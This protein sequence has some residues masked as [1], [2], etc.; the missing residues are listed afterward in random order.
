MTADPKPTETA[1]SAPAQPQSQSVRTEHTVTIQGKPIAYTAIAGTHILNEERFGEGDKKDVYEGEKARVEIFYTAYL[2]KDVDD[3]RERPITFAFNGGPGAP[4]LWVHMGLLGPKRVALNEDG[5]PLPPPAKMIENEYSILDQT[6]LVMIDPVGTGFSRAVSGDKPKD[7]WGW[8]KDVESIG[9]FI[10]SFIAANGRWGSP[11]YIAG[12]SYGT[13][14]TTGLA[15]YLSD[16]HGM[17]LNGIILIST[18][19]DFMTL[20]FFDGNDLPYVT[21]LPTY[22]AAAWYH[23]KIAPKYRNYSLER[24]I[25]DSASFAEDEYLSALFAGDRLRDDYKRSVA[26]KLADWTGLS[27][28]FI[29]DSNLRVPMDRFGKELLRS[30]GKVIG[31]FDAR[32]SGPDKDGA[33]QSPSY[34]PSDSELSGVFAGALN[35]YLNRELNYKTERE[36]TIS[37]ELWRIWDYKEF[38]NRYLQLEEMLRDTMIRNKFMR[39]WVL[40]GYY[41]LATPFFAS[42]F[43]F[44]H[45]NLPE[46]LRQ[47]IIMT[48]YE[49]GHMMYVHQ[50]SLVKFRRDAEA[51]FKMQEQTR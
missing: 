4:S 5:S 2:K 46:P 30:E 40:N 27:L 14:R 11:K 45:L 16:K 39:V 44:N 38:Q 20:D 31:R 34:D 43:V 47:N 26:K 50:P 8:K 32:F 35:D 7:Y 25:S 17:Y 22:A 42:E 6:D 13:T 9:E 48:Y 23:G 51:F 36:Y 10:R 12:E 3:V 29:L 37:N 28:K 49:A 18:A 41:D 1:A 21:F 33:G 24:V 15:D 19:L